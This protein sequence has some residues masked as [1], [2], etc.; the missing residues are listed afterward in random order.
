M[1]SVKGFGLPAAIFVITVLAVIISGMS[2]IQQRSSQSLSLQANS[3]RAFYAAESGGQL[4][5]NLLFPPAGGS[6]ECNVSPYYQHD[7]SVAGL[8]GCSVTVNCRILSDSSED[9]FILTSTGQCG[10]AEDQAMRSI[11]VMVH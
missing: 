3:Y 6:Q 9:Y 2:V 11:E 8:A 7:F 10:S 5:L 1:R 4:A